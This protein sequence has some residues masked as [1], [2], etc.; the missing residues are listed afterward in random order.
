MKEVNQDILKNEPVTAEERAAQAKE[1]AE[2]MF[3]DQDIAS[4]LRK[5][6]FSQ[7]GEE[8][9]ELYNKSNLQFIK[10]PT[11]PLLFEIDGTVDDARLHLVMYF[12]G[13]KRIFNPDASNCS[14]LNGSWLSSDET[15]DLWE[16]YSTIARAQTSE[17]VST[18]AQIFRH[19]KVEYLKSELGWQKAIDIDL[20]NI[21]TQIEQ[22]QQS[23][24]DLQKIRADLAV[25]DRKTK[26]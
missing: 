4:V 16:R 12:D 13:V 9:V 2:V 24:R 26:R 21:D 5:L 8:V 22:L 3:R 14:T 7:F 23:R 20:K 18:K 19:K 11:S 15:R 25:Q 1:E 10:S 17:K 6:I